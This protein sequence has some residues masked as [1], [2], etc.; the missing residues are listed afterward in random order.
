MPL[1]R[2][3]NDLGLIFAVLARTQRMKIVSRQNLVFACEDSL[4]SQPKCCQWADRPRATPSDVVAGGVLYRIRMLPR[5][6]PGTLAQPGSTCGDP[7]SYQSIEAQSTGD[8]DG[9]GGRLGQ[10]GACQAN[11][12]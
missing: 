6:Q 5:L 10:G 1:V 3:V 12:P 4:D 7:R 2:P 11:L 9:T 8:A